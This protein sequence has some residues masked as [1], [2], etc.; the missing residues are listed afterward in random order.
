MGMSPDSNRRLRADASRNV[1]RLLDAAR[2]LLAEAGNEVPLDEIA[3]HAGVGNAT[4]YRHFPT[5]ADLLVAVYAEEIGTLCRRGTELLNCAEPLDALFAWLDEFVVHVATKRAL[6]LA[7]T[8]AGGR[9]T[10]LFHQWHE[11]INATATRLVQR[12]QPPLRADLTATDL[13][14]LVSGAA[15]ATDTVHARRLVTLLRTGLAQVQ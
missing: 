11:S 3:R 6:A 14:T 12:A 2:Q 7:A 13:L 1:A 5:R 15:L 10:S 9:R 4:L 8:E